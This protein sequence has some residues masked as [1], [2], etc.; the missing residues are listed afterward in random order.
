MH[1]GGVA[2]DHEVIRVLCA[3]SS[4]AFGDTHVVKNTSLT[5]GRGKNKRTVE[6]RSTNYDPAWNLCMETLELHKERWSDPPGSRWVPYARPRDSFKMER[7][8]RPRR[9]AARSKIQV[10]RYALDSSVLP[11]VTET[12]PVA[13]AAPRTLMGIHGRLTEK[14]GIRGRSNAFSGKDEG[15]KRLEGHRHAYYLPADEDRDRR[16]DH[17]TVFAA[18]GFE[19]EELKALDRLHNLKSNRRGEE[20]H[21]L[22][23]LLLG[24]G[25]LGKYQ[26]GPLGTSREWVSATPYLAARYAKSRGRQRIDMASPEAR[27][28][29]LA[30]DALSQLAAVRSDLGAGILSRVAIE[31]LWDPNHVFR[32]ACR[33]RNADA[34]RSRLRAILKPYRAEIG[35]TLAKYNPRIERHPV[36][37][38]LR[39]TIPFVD[40]STDSVCDAIRGLRRCESFIDEA[41]FLADKTAV[42][43]TDFFC[44]HPTVRLTGV[45]RTNAG[46]VGGWKD[47]QRG[48]RFD[49]S[50][51]KCYGTDDLADPYNWGTDRRRSI[52]APSAS[53]SSR[54][55]TRSTW[56]Q[57]FI[58]RSAERSRSTA[59]PRRATS[60]RSRSKRPSRSGRSTH[61]SWSRS[62]NAS[63]S[64]RTTSSAPVACSRSCSAINP[65]MG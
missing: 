44:E 18:G 1:A 4:S 65:G 57:S 23:L 5:T 34:V 19:P 54:T 25:T 15:G 60:S 31:P 27:A 30:G 11:L 56:S 48:G 63:P 35:R 29:F 59:R 49:G 62:K 14:N 51:L 45:D 2:Q 12:L 24:M 20:R 9:S 6:E 28:E 39:G 17:L 53:W 38:P 37:E 43:R 46:S 41:L 52:A 47:S 64:A 3:D 16:L 13:E 33:W 36:H 32:I 61:G 50:C 21:P 22:R 10:V 58:P 26:P 42:W 40:V 55:A 8:A 7:M